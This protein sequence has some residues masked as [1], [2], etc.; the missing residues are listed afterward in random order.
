M[1]KQRIEQ[2]LKGEDEIIIPYQAKWNN[3]VRAREEVIKCV[4][5]QHCDS[6]L[7]SDANWLLRSQYTSCEQLGIDIRPG[8][9]CY[10]DYGQAYL[11]EIGFQHFGLVLSIY[12]K[13]AFVIPMTSNELQYKTAYDL[14][15]NPSGKRHL[16][17]LGCLPGMNKPSVLF[18]ND[19]K[20]INTARII[21]VKAHLEISSPCYQKIKKR[22]IKCISS[23]ESM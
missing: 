18:L 7:V 1:N 4:D 20:Y 19:C 10:I 15:D 2:V 16:M 13:K 14:I 17:R 11:N 3:F 6:Y 22:I 9:I 12:Q 21:D 8:D 5:E 23:S